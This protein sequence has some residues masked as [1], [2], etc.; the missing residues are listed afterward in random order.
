MS[1][2]RPVPREFRWG[3][4]G[5]VWHRAAHL[6]PGCPMVAV[7]S[8]D[9][10]VGRSTL[11]AAL[12]GLL[13]LACPAPV[14]AVDVTARAWGGLGER[15]GRGT[16]TS[17]WDAVAAG[18]RL[19]GPLIEQLAQRGP[20]GLRVLVGEVEMTA[21]RR[22]PVVLEVAAAVSRLR[23]WYPLDDLFQGVD[24][25]RNQWCR[26]ACRSSLKHGR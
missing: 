3:R 25:S 23:R 14:V 15:V 19:D 9:G 2:P 16:P 18:V 17:V 6:A 26:S 12:G 4:A 11:V 22:P 8:A 20:T 1:A 10:G 24:L 5:Q 21:A 7:S 13:A